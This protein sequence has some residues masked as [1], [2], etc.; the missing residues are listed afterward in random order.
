MESNWW[1]AT[2]DVYKRQGFTPRLE[3]LSADG[4]WKGNLPGRGVVYLVLEHSGETAKKK[5]AGLGH[6][7]KT[8]HYYETVSYTHLDWLP[9]V[10]TVVLVPELVPLRPVN[11]PGK[12]PAAAKKSSFVI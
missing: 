4:R 5:I 10:R 11:P 12:Q 9:D 2:R 6:L 8:M 1:L 7:V 3:E